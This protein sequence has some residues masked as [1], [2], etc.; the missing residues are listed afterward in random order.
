MLA[1]ERRHNTAARLIAIILAF[2]QIGAMRPAAAQGQVPVALRLGAPPAASASAMISAAEGGVVRLGGAEVEIPAG[3]LAGDTEI[4]IT[5][6]HEVEET[7]EEINNAT[8]GGGGY[9]F[10]PAGAKFAIPAS[11]D[12]A[13]GRAG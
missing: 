5:R 10:E 1:M 11:A 3:A 6:L 9:R 7:G 8:A 4:R 2:L 12:R 13:Q